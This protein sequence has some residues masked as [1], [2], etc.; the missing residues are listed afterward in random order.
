[1]NITKN[2]EKIPHK[3]S[4]KVKIFLIASFIIGIGW[5]IYVLVNVGVLKVNNNALFINEYKVPF[6]GW[7]KEIKDIEKQN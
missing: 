6:Y 2:T 4:F 1:M 7:T 3:M 5:N